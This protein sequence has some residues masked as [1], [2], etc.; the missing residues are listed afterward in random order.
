M[1]TRVSVEKVI[2]KTLLVA[3]ACGI[4]C[5]TTSAVTVPPGGTKPIS[6]QPPT[7]QARAEIKWV[8]EICV[9]KDR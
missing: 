7:Q 2:G 4:F 5:P 8:K 3:V 6:Y 1:K 9:E